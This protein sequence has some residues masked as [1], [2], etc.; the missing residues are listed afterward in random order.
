MVHVKV[1]GN[2]VILL[3]QLTLSVFKDLTSIRLDFNHYDIYDIQSHLES[4]FYTKQQVS[5]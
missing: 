2:K 3:T 1:G 4:S 5:T